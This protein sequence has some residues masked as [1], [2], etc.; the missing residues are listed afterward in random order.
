[1]FFVAILQKLPSRNLEER[2]IGLSLQ[3]KFYIGNETTSTF[4][5]I[6]TPKF[7]DLLFN[8]IF[9]LIYGFVF[10]NV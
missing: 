3:G 4:E 7:S 10:E 1:M 5:E 9:I 6:I 2:E 8:I